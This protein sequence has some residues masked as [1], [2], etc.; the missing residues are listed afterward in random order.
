MET[1]SVP[2]YMAPE[3]VTQGAAGAS[4]VADSYSLAIIAVEVLTLQRAYI[5]YKTGQFLVKVCMEGKRPN[6]SMYTHMPAPVEGILR[7]AWRQSVEK[8]WT[9][10]QIH[11]GFQVMMDRLE[12]RD[13]VDNE[14]GQ[15][16]QDSGEQSPKSRKSALNLPGEKTRVSK[17]ISVSEGSILDQSSVTGTVDESSNMPSDHLRLLEPQPRRSR[18]SRSYREKTRASKTTRTSISEGSIAEE[19]EQQSVDGSMRSTST[20]DYGRLDPQHKPHRRPPMSGEELGISSKEEQLSPGRASKLTVDAI[21]K[22]KQLLSPRRASKQ[23]VDATS[24]KEKQSSPRRPSKQTQQRRPTRRGLATSNKALSMR[25]ISSTSKTSSKKKDLWMSQSFG[26][27]HLAEKALQKQSFGKRSADDGV[28]VFEPEQKQSAPKTS[29]RKSSKVLRNIDGGAPIAFETDM[30]S[31]R[32]DEAKSDGAVEAAKVSTQGEA[33]GSTVVEEHDGSRRQESDGSEQQRDRIE[34]SESQQEQTEASKDGEDGL[35]GEKGVNRETIAS[36]SNHALSASSKRSEKSSNRENITSSSH[37]TLSASSAHSTNN[38]TSAADAIVMEDGTTIAVKKP[39]KR[40]SKS[41][42]SGKKKEKRDIGSKREGS[43]KPPSLR[44]MH[45][46]VGKKENEDAVPGP[47]PLRRA[48]SGSSLWDASKSRKPRRKMSDAEDYSIQPDK[49]GAPEPIA[50]RRA[51]SGSSVTGESKIRK[52]RRKVSDLDGDSTQ[53]SESKSGAPEEP[54]LRRAQSGSSADEPKTR[55]SN[56][57]EEGKKRRPLARKKSADKSTHNV[58]SGADDSNPS[59]TKKLPR[60]K[61]SHN[62]S[63]K[64]KVTRTKSGSERLMSANAQSPPE[65]EAENKANRRRTSVNSEEFMAE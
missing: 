13:E 34:Q 11:E 25:D 24:S 22:E 1:G 6:M 19:Q 47:T 37:H 60:R 39:S 30:A 64:K 41:K 51:Q 26:D 16:E 20:S 45:S 18:G 35:Q 14:Q 8:R 28:L 29:S 52:H 44:R 17:S 7:R 59:A 27:V 42:S 10:A 53:Q 33:E 49:S 2:R 43:T 12:G 57:S 23:P 9:C 31:M 50:L 32:P 62:N 63:A 58:S 21:S 40:S 15:I 54:A 4:L 38:A 46:A 61:N 55:K 56:A 48:K 5:S 36:E 3:I 65:G